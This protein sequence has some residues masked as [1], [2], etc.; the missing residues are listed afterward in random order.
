MEWEIRDTYPIIINSMTSVILLTGATGFV[1]R[2]VLRALHPA[3]VSLRLVVR[4]G[5]KIP[6]EFDADI[7]D[8][9]F[10]PDLFMES[11]SWWE[12]AC[13]G[14][15]IIIHLAWYT[16]PG[17]YQES[18]R[19]IDCQYGTMNLANG[20]IRAGI[21]RFVGIGTCFE[22]DLSSEVIS[23]QTPLNPLTPYAVAKVT[24][25]KNLLRC[26]PEEHIEFVWC[27]LFY[28]YGEGEDERRLAPY[29][30]S[31]LSAGQTANLTEGS[32]VRDYLDV[33]E[34]GKM[35]V[36]VA[37]GNIRGPVNI[38]SGIAVSV[39]E[40]AES[41]ADEYGRRDLLRFGV[42]TSDS[43]DPPRIVGVK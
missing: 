23:N 2:Q 39:R 42:R 11:V 38:C 15:D 9:I 35:V 33:R 13:E 7:E 19:N 34:A 28:L 30:R 6:E 21:R 24:V 22:Y 32:Q 27:R 4:E 41:I 36:E 5:T 16:E 43:F 37:L 40:F 18:P 20:C 8:L 17:I 3:D 10:T 31:R 26:L 25:Y 14:V 1:G 29:I 12:K